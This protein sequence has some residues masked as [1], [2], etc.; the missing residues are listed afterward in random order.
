MNPVPLQ[1]PLSDPRGAKA[2]AE[3][4]RRPAASHNI[5]STGN[6]GP[7]VVSQSQTLLPRMRAVGISSTRVAGT[8]VSHGSGGSRAI[9]IEEVSSS[10]SDS[11][12]TMAFST[13]AHRASLPKKAQDFK[14]L[15]RTRVAHC[16]GCSSGRCPNESC[17]WCAIEGSDRNKRDSCG[18]LCYKF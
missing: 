3:A 13:Y 4:R 12:Q 1:S 8:R 16:R 18:S 15:T 7:P 2:E 17:D 11:T 6:L 14:T 9:A 5:A 10:T